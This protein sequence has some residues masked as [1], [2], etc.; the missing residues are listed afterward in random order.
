MFYISQN[1]TVGMEG[2]QLD[3]NLTGWLISGRLGRWVVCCLEPGKTECLYHDMPC[4]TSY[5]MARGK[6]RT[7]PFSWWLVAPNQECW[8][9]LDSRVAI[10]R[11]WVMLENGPCAAQQGETPS[12][13]FGKSEPQAE[14][15]SRHG[16]P[17]KQLSRKP[18]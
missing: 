11:N 10:Q 7:I 18:L 5:P 14:G 8:S 6:G 16:L 3:K 17:G 12:P 9:L 13:A 1:A 2:Q 15:Q 4:L